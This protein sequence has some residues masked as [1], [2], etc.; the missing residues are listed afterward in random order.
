MNTTRFFADCAT[1][2]AIKKTYKKLAMQHHPDLGG[3]AEIMKDL[4]NQYHEALKACDGVETDGHTYSYKANVEQEIMDKLN[5]LLKL[6]GLEIDLIGCWLWIAGKTRE[7]K[8]ALKELS[9]RW[10]SKRKLWFYKPADWKSRRYSKGSLDDLAAKYGS[11]KFKSGKGKKPQKTGL[12]AP[13][14]AIA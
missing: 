13:R 4:N 6:E 5:A 8:E 3:D 2:E 9:C 14:R 10:H 11:E 1:V 12:A 7:N